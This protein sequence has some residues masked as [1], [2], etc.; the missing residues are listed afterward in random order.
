MAITGTGTELDPFI[1]HSYDEIKTAAENHNG[2]QTMYYMKL[3]NDIDCNDYGADFQWET[4]VLANNSLTTALNRAN[5]IDLDGHTIKNV[6]IK[7]ANKLFDSP[8][9]GL[10]VVKNG[11]ILNVFGSNPTEF[12]LKVANQNISFSIQFS[13]LSGSGLFNACKLQNCAVYVILLFSTGKSIFNNNGDLNLNN[14][15][16]YAEMYNAGSNTTICSAGNASVKYNGIRLNGKMK[17][18]DPNISPSKFLATGKFTYSVIN[19]DLTDYTYSGDNNSNL[20][21]TGDNTT[22]VNSQLIPTLDNALRLS[23]YIRA[24]TAQMTVGEDLRNLGFSV[25]NVEE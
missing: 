9:T 20:M 21:D 3:A 7:D 18:A 15:D 2:S 25:V 11:K 16:V 10:A 23:N 12:M 14:V 24:T 17:F 1:V 13:T 5:T 4:I 22:V 6:F 19:F 8:S